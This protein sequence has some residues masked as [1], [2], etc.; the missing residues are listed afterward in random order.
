MHVRNI[1]ELNKRS[2][3]NIICINKTLTP[4]PQRVNYTLKSEYKFTYNRGY[5]GRMPPRVCARVCVTSRAE[6]FR[7]HSPVISLLIN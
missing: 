4:R 7:I 3:W 2:K 6:W 5:R 1:D